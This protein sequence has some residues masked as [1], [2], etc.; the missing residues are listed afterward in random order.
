L[1]AEISERGYDQATVARIVR[2][3]GVSRRT[4]YE[5]FSDREDCALALFEVAVEQAGARVRDACA[6]EREW[7]DRVRTGLCTIL[8]LMDDEPALA[9]LCILEMPTAGDRARAG[10]REL[11]DRLGAVL[12]E[13]RATWRVA[14]AHAQATVGGVLA[15]IHAHM[16]EANGEPLVG[17]SR[18]LMSMIV[19]PYLGP[20]GAHHELRLG[21]PPAQ[22]SAPRSVR[23]HAPATACRLRLTRRAVQTLAVVDAAPGSSNAQIGREVGIADAG[24][25]SKLLARLARH[26]LIDKTHMPR[27]RGQPN[28]WSLTAEGHVLLDSVS[29]TL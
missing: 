29:R 18:Q 3:A 16:L 27:T 22:A 4:F 17:L 10:R 25:I 5:L 28:A 1:I 15:M 7:V 24:Q 6:G 20:D 21:S 9:R 13:G 14:S 11:L 19:L 26:G 2:R 12:D 8:S 23:G